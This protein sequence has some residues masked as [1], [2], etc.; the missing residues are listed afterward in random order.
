M[1]FLLNL[2]L[3]NGVSRQVGKNKR[4]YYLFVALIFPVSLSNT[5]FVIMAFALNLDVV[6][7]VIRVVIMAFLAEPGCDPC[8]D[9]CCDHGIPRSTWM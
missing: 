6:L 5:C 8:S 1:A 4:S 9:L 2:E 3:N 7:V